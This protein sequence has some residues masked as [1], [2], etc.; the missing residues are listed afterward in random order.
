LSGKV[1]EMNAQEQ[2]NPFQNT[3]FERMAI[4]GALAGSTR[5]RGEGSPKPAP[6]LA[7]GQLWQ[8]NGAY[9]EVVGTNKRLVLYRVLKQKGQKALTRVLKRELFERCLKEN[10]ATLV[11]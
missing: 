9:I 11:E 10:G 2:V 5:E 8:L 6:V 1:I 3:L 7:H 4:A